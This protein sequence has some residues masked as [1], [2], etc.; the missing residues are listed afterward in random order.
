VPAR[1]ASARRANPY[2]VKLHRSYSVAEL[3]VCLSVHK[4]TVGLWQ[5][6]G[7]QPID[8]SRPLLFQGGAVR[9]FLSNRN[10][11]R[12][13]PCT[14]GTLY[15]LRCREP[16]QPATG[17]VGYHPISATSGNLRATCGT[18]AAIMHRRIRL[19]D[20]DAKMPGLAIPI[21][22]AFSRLGERTDPSLNCDFERQTLK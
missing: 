14:P 10:K 3:A 5:S 17:T 18:C 15:C 7:L 12:K 13:R 1:R 20:L 11:A 22:Q 8:K 4:N 16:R 2:G 21:R 19:T 9:A 6:A